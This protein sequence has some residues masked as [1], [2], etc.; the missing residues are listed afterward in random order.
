MKKYSLLIFIFIL[1]LTAFACKSEIIYGRWQTNYPG[2]DN[3]VNL[4][5][6]DNG[7]YTYSDN[8]TSLNGEYSLDENVLRLFYK[9][10]GKSKNITMTI[11]ELTDIKLKVKTEIQGKER[12]I[13]FNKIIDE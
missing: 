13:I 2:T 12:E 10:M 4:L 6:N 11:L 1:T 5:I 3:V 8:S 9:V 7:T